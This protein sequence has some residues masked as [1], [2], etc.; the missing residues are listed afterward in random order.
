MLDRVIFLSETAHASH[1]AILAADGG[2]DGEVPG[3]SKIK[4]EAVFNAALRLLNNAPDRSELV[5]A[6][7]EEILNECEGAAP[8]VQTQSRA[9][10]KG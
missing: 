2:V 1:Q 3:V 10:K 5:L 7:L 6:G 4:S 9:E 8:A